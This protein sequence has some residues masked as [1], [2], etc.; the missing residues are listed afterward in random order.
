MRLCIK[1]SMITIDQTDP[2]F[3]YLYIQKER[4]SELVQEIPSGAFWKGPFFPDTSI[5]YNTVGSSLLS[6]R[7]CLGGFHL[8]LGYGGQVQPIGFTLPNSKFANQHFFPF[9]FAAFDGSSM[10]V[11]CSSSARKRSKSLSKSRS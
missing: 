9:G 3:I 8:R 1:N 4:F 6:M 2:F 11:A 7:I 10:A 5:K